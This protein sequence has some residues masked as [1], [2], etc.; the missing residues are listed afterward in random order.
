MWPSR[1]ETSDLITF[2]EE[3]FSGKLSFLRGD[4]WN[5]A[6]D[7]FLSD[8]ANYLHSLKKSIGSFKFV[9]KMVEFQQHA[10]LFSNN[11]RKQ[12]RPSSGPYC[13]G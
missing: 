12:V 7:D 8:R 11:T 5:N 6:L 4:F 9:T 2:T 1:Q 3:I 13:I 10:W